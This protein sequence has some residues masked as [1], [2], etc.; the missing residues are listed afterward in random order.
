MC[1]CIYFTK[2][3]LVYDF[4]AIL[5]M[6]RCWRIFLLK[7]I[8]H[9]TLAPNFI[10]I[11]ISYESSVP[12]F[13][14]SVLDFYL[15]PIS[16]INWLNDSRGRTYIT[17]DISWCL[18]T[19]DWNRISSQ[20]ITL[21]FGIFPGLYIKF[22]HTKRTE[23]GFLVFIKMEL[24]HFIYLLKILVKA[25]FKRTACLRKCLLNLPILC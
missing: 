7:I 3:L 2:F 13:F 23:N 8:A 24:I 17:R 16:Q 5:Y 20:V 22:L 18:C 21:L 15:I 4:T 10:L 12:W 25:Y 6:K 19:S 14:M 11:V 9:Y 1:S